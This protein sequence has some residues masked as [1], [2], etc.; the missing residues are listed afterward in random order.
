LKRKASNYPTTDKSRVYIA[1]VWAIRATSSRRGD[2]SHRQ[3]RVRAMPREITASTSDVQFERPPFK[4]AAAAGQS[5]VP[6]SVTTT[7]M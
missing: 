3:S 6:R 2:L 7:F 4:D 1:K 5:Y